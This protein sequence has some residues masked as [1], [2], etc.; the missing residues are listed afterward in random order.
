MADNITLTIHIT[1]NGQSRTLEV[2]PSE[3]LLSVL[4]DRL[5]LTGTKKC[6][7]V[8]EC[9]ACTVVM[10]GLSVNSC[11][12]LAAEADGADV[13][14]IEG[15]SE[16]GSPGR[17]Q[18]AFLDEGAVQCGFCTPG[19]V[20]SAHALLMKNPSPTVFEIKEGLSG[21]LCRCTGYARIIR[22]VQTAAGK[23]GGE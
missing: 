5:N 13:V 22:A 7:G 17:I 20:M 6:C 15:L 18:Q 16:S 21:N 4:R 19:M 9:G 14:T 8:G 10:N 2:D 1:V 23:G 11:I 3:T 12:I